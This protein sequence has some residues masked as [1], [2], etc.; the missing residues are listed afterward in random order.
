[1]V[2]DALTEAITDIRKHTR[3]D[4]GW[5]NPLGF[6][7]F[8]LKEIL[9]FLNIP[10]QTMLAPMVTALL[11][12]AIFTTAWQRS[13]I[14]NVAFG[15]FLACGLVVMSIMQNS[16]ANGSS[17]VMHTKILG[18]I[19]DILMPPLTPLELSLAY[20]GASITRGLVVGVIVGTAMSFFVEDPQISPGWLL[21]Y[22]LNAAM[23][24]SGL[25]VLAGVW[26]EKFDHMSSITNFIIMPL[27]FLSGTF[28][29]VSSLPP[30]WRPLALFNPVHYAIDGFRYAVIGYNDSSLAVGASVCLA[31]NVVLLFFCW[32]AFKTGYRLET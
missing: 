4:F 2:S 17:S 32:L 12:L 8:F 5:F 7:T 6:R 14:G 27:T 10:M 3:R 22:S 20:L 15:S 26:A 30:D 28:Y 11:F 23:M 31:V 21:F 18:N 1:M 16:F 19:G 25:G 29:S 24:M 9:R 13:D